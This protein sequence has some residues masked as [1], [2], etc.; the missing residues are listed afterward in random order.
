MVVWISND[1]ET[2][3]SEILLKYLN[4]NKKNDHKKTYIFVDEWAELN[5]KCKKIIKNIMINRDQYNVDVIIA[6]QLG[7]LFDDTMKKSAD[8]IIEL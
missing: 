8:K 5:R 4:E 2:A 1:F 7:E 6:T 3:L